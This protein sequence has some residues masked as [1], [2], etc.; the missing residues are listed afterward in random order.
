MAF[1]S[2]QQI[3]VHGANLLTALIRQRLHPLNVVLQI[4]LTVVAESV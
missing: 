2:L 3:T 4:L 1:D